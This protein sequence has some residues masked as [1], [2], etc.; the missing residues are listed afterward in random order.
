MRAT[1]TIYI[2]LSVLFLLLFAKGLFLVRLA[3]PERGDIPSRDQPPLKAII[4][5]VDGMRADMIDKMEI[6][7][8]LN[9]EH[10]E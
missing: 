7:H 9:T 8:R 1:Y 6:Y 4:L 10:P 5:L 3:L 2:C